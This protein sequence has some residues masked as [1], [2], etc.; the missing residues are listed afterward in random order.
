MRMPIMNNLSAMAF[1]KLYEHAEKVKEGVWTFQQAMECRIGSEC[2][3]Y[4]ELFETVQRH[5]QEAET[6]AAE[7]LALMPVS[8]LFPVDKYQF[9]NWLHL[10]DQVLPL[11]LDAMRWIRHRHATVSEE[12]KGR[13]ILLMDAIPDPVEELG[14]LVQETRK[15]L[16]SFSD[17]HRSSV[18]DVVQSIHQEVQETLRICDMVHE[19][20]FSA[21]MDPLSACHL[22]RLSE[23]ILKVAVQT[24]TIADVVRAMTLK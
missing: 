10:Q 3:S 9:F 13:L 8:V 2:P 18:M 7:V 4:G 6:I 15:Y 11:A 5:Q 19:F 21:E 14:K 16:R 17:K 24:R 20:V 1:D 12:L 23:K 22:I